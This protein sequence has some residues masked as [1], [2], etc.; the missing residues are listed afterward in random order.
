MNDGRDRHRSVPGRRAIGRGAVTNGNRLISFVCEL[1]HRLGVGAD[2]RGPA[3]ERFG[4]RR[5][6]LGLGFRVAL[7]LEGAHRGGGAEVA[8]GAGG[9]GAQIAA[10]CLET[11]DDPVD[12]GRVAD[13]SQGFERRADEQQRGAGDLG[14][15]ALASTA[16]GEDGVQRVAY[17]RVT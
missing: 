16:R 11:R 15:V 7:M 9:G 17:R 13:D 14:A 3:P 5:Q 12:V 1:P 2:L 10:T 8:E 6:H 4:D